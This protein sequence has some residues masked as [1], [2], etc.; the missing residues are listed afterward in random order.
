[1]RLRNDGL[2]FAEDT[3]PLGSVLTVGLLSSR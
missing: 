3:K 2:L 1:M